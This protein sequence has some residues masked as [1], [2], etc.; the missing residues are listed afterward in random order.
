MKY[1]IKPSPIEGLG[2][3][4]T[5]MINKNEVI[6]EY[7]GLEMSWREFRQ[8]YGLYKNNSL[9]TYPQRRIWK[10]IVAKDE[11]YKSQNMVNYINEGIPNVYL[12]NKLLY[13]LKDIQ[14][15]EELLLIYPKDYNRN[16]VI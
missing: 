12:K 8:L 3:F 4:A 6:A 10:I 7:Y 9:N 2:V 14:Q 11:P 5:S 1:E 16:W 15:G 13:A